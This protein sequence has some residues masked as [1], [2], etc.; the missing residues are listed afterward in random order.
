MP[1][2]PFLPITSLSAIDGDSAAPGTLVY[3]PHKRFQHFGLL[4]ADQDGERL[5]MDLGGDQPLG[6]T[7]AGEGVGTVLAVADWRIEVDPTSALD[8]QHDRLA[9]GVAFTAGTLHGLVGNWLRGRPQA[10]AISTS[11]SIAGAPAGTHRGAYSRWRIVTGAPER[12]VQLVDSEH[13]ASAAA[14]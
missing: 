14:V 12:P 4:A 5:V 3:F 8:I 2:H 13:L 1:T 11:G 10:I 9:A 7:G 6:I